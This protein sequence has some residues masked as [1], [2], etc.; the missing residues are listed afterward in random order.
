MG[1]VRKQVQTRSVPVH[2]AA[3]GQQQ[4]E[5]MR[6]LAVA[7]TAARANGLWGDDF[8]LAKLLRVFRRGARKAGRF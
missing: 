1:R 5:M 7:V 8:Q 2:R 6:A 4:R 3:Q